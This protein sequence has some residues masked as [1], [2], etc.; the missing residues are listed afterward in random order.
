MAVALE[1]A[2]LVLFYNPIKS[3]NISARNSLKLVNLSNN[4]L[5]PNETRFFVFVA[6]TITQSESSTFAPSTL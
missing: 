1:G 4:R 3:L 5:C 6:M 2:Q